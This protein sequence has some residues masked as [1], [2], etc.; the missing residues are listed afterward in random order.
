MVEVIWLSVVVREGEVLLS[1]GAERFRGIAVEAE[2]VA[3]AGSESIPLG[4]WGAMEAVAVL[5]GS[6]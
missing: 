2:M 4:R 6:G 1:S 5:G 3:G